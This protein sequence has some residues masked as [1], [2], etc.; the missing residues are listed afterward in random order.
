MRR[1]WFAFYVD[2]FLG[3]EVVK[4]S[5]N[6]VI[7]AYVRLLCRQWREGSVPAEATALAAIAHERPKDFQPIWKAL[8][9]KFERQDGRLVNRRP[10][11]ERVKAEK[12]SKIAGDSIRSQNTGEVRF[13]YAA[14]A[15]AF[16]PGHFDAA[17]PL[18]KI[19]W[20]RNPKGRMSSLR[21]HTY[22]VYP[23]LIGQVE[24]SIELERRAHIDLARHLESD[25]WFHDVPEVRQWINRHG[26]TAGL[27]AGLTGQETGYTTGI[28]AE[29]SQSHPQSQS[30]S[31][32]H[33]PITVGSS[34]EQKREP[35][36]AGD[37]AYRVMRK[38][39]R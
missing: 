13:L 34:E 32:N 16:G 26:L 23:K 6:R 33:L 25:E 22:H 7:G 27:T 35:E 38:F 36:V 17:L 5:G 15:A 39:R 1:P 19:G 20:S 12:R 8:G 11:D 18:V 3:D 9:C 37:I 24:A 28:P 30:Q 14:E 2:D 4:L 31:T 21:H 29:Q 10:D